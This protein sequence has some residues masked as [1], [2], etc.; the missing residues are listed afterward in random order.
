MPEN[1][2]DRSAVHLK[3]TGGGKHC[4]QVRAQAA[5][6]NDSSFLRQVK[7]AEFVTGNSG[8][9]LPIFSRNWKNQVAIHVLNSAWRNSR[10]ARETMDDLK[11]RHDDAGRMSPTSPI[12]ARL[13]ISAI[14]QDGLVHISVL[15]RQIWKG[16]RTKWL[17]LAISSRSR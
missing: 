16:I 15:S 5:I 1:P 7:P 17:K 12:L 10:M 2:L 8:G 6:A 14:R 9:C 4:P 3:P 11:P 13:W